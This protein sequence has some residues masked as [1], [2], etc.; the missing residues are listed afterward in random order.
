[1]VKGSNQH[2]IAERGPGR[3]TQP[4]VLR[5]LSWACIVVF[6]LAA[7]FAAS[8][9]AQTVGYAPVALSFGVPSGTTYTVA[10]STYPGSAPEVVTVIVGAS[11]SSPVTFPMAATVTGTNSTDFII[12]GN[13]CTGT[14]TSPNTCQLTLHFNASKAPANT[15]ETALLTI[16][17]SASPGVLTVPLS[18]AYGSIKIF[19]ETNITPAPSSAS[20]SNLYAIATKT[21]NLTC[22]SSPVTAT[23]SGTPD[24]SGYILVDNYLTLATGPVSAAVPPPPLTPVSDQPFSSEYPAG[25]ICGGPGSSSDYDNVH[26]SDDNNCVSEDYVTE[27][28]DDGFTPSNSDP[29]SFANPG[30]SVLPPV[31]HG[32]NAGGVPPIDIHAFLGG[33]PSGSYPEQAL[34]TLS[35]SGPEL[36]YDNSTLFLVTNCTAPG[37]VPGASATLNPISTTAPATQTQTATLDNSPGQNISFTYG[38]GVAIQNDPTILN[39]G[40][41]P[42]VTDF[43][44]PQQLF[45]QLVGPST[46]AAPAV[47]MRVAGELDSSGN[48][49]CKGFLLQCYNSSTGTTTGQNCSN[50]SSAL[51]S[52]YLLFT[53]QFT[54]PDGPSGY[55]YLTTQPWAA[56][57]GYSLGQTIV[58][59]V[60]YVQQVTTAGTSGGTIPSPFN[61]TVGGTTS[62]GSVTWTNEGVNSC[63][64]MGPGVACAQGTG[65]GLLMGGDNWLCGPGSTAVATGT[66]L[67]CAPPEPPQIG[68]TTGPT[69]PA[70]EPNAG[71]PWYVASDCVLTGGLAG[72]P[73]PLNVMSSVLGAADIGPKGSTGASNSLFVPVVNMPLPTSSASLGSGWIDGWT[74]TPSTATVSF[75]TNAASYPSSGTIPPS[76]GFVAAPI[77]SLTAGFSPFNQALPD[78]TYPVS[79]D[80]TLTNTATS[81]NTPFCNVGGTTPASFSPT[82]TVQNLNGGSGPADG[83]YYLHYFPTDCAFTEGLLYNPTPAQVT[84]PTAN[85]ASFRYLTVG[86]DTLAPT[87]AACSTPTVRGSNPPVP[88]IPTASGWY[89]TDLT[90]QCEATDQNYI[91]GQSGSGF[92]PL[93][94]N[95]MQGSASE[96]IGVSTNVGASNFNSAAYTSAPSA[97]DVANNCGT[98]AAGGPFM[99]DEQAPLVSGSAGSSAVGGTPIGVTFTCSDAG[100]GI[101]SGGCA[102]GN[103]PANYTPNACS[104]ASGAS[105][106]CGGTI[107][108]GAAESGTLTFTATD[109]AGNVTSTTSG[110]TVGQGGQSITL[111]T[112]P[113]AVY[114]SNFTALATGGGSGNPVTFTSGGGCS[115][116]GAN[117]TMTSGTTACSVIANQAGNSNYMAAPQV[118][119]I[120]GA[121]LATATITLG[122]APTATYPGNN[123]TISATTNSNAPLT[124]GYVSGPCSLV[125]AS[126][127]TF[128]PT[129]IGNCTA[130]VSTAA[131]T[132]FTA[133]STMQ[134]VNIGAA[135]WTIIPS[136]YAF[137]ELSVGQK[138]SQQFEIYNPGPNSSPIL[139]SIPANEQGVEHPADFKI[140]GNTCGATLAAGG[141]CFVTVTFTANQN[142]LNLP[143]PGDSAYLTV[144]NGRRTLLVQ[145]YMTAETANPVISLPSSY[146]FGSQTTGTPV[147][148]QVGTLTNTGPT[149]LI[150]GNLLVT[151][152]SFKLATGSGTNCTKDGTVAPGA[153]CVIYATFTPAKK[154]KAYTGTITLNSNAANA[155]LTVT[156]SGTGD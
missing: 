8:A 133:A 26:N 110:Y 135:P 66:S 148:A 118:T 28:Y 59:P 52:R 74:N 67:T 100:S 149:T 93:L 75:T 95:S 2:A 31:V 144:K 1:M 42:I 18:G 12:D 38:T 60:G 106:T 151:S 61:E 35:T 77:Y 49:M 34:F 83:L 136:P 104:P 79:T 21:L 98:G 47:C 54:S 155:P 88:A 15:L 119:N 44:I 112:P 3:K 29:D 6:A 27:I 127:G 13:S 36:V 99:I 87:F 50:S 57:Y 125:S 70:G 103:A 9:Q 55:N 114:G 154:G 68:A 137:P 11:A 58:D 143:P 56:N 89:N 24:G 113:T 97:C 94:P 72:A 86:I 102:I 69:I 117:F 124:Y 156:L 96:S 33:S 101:P 108:T 62:D 82:A 20:F 121:T 109:N 48:P 30:N 92:L 132:N 25:N 128:A 107:A 145:G 19:D 51:Q 39:T 152:G 32:T 4:G 84:D 140:T 17:S 123:F 80:D 146:N 126:A 85:W 122:A 63:L 141:T 138:A 73:C 65:P 64:N 40:I 37:I 131:T 41:V 43:P 91:L 5:A 153:S 45:S 81:P 78:T 130:Q 134:T 90:E 76:N 139:A 111:T 150:F 7:S 120:V 105:V 129:G 10:P 14:F 16:N 115:N 71:D 142:G 46:S 23:I 22:A 116:S 53:T 147:T